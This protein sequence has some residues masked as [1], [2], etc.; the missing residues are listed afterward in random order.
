MVSYIVEK[1]Y[2]ESQAGSDKCAPFKGL[3]DS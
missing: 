3:L 1:A 2:E